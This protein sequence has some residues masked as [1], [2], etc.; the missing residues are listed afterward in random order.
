[1]ADILQS[2]QGAG[3]DLKRYLVDTFGIPK[4]AT[5]FEVCF[6]DGQPVRVRC[7]YVAV[8]GDDEPD[9]DD[10]PA[11]PSHGSLDD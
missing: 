10:E 3:A 1:M 2:D 11:D 9:A 7:E 6:A 5:S 4:T 8:M